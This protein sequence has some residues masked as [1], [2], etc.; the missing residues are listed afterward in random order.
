MVVSGELTNWGRY[1]KKRRGKRRSSTFGI[2]TMKANRVQ[3]KCDKA[4]S[5]PEQDFKKKEERNEKEEKRKNSQERGGYLKPGLQGKI[6]ERC[7]GRRVGKRVVE[8]GGGVERKEDRARPHHALGR[9]FDR[10]NRIFERGGGSERIADLARRKH[11]H[12]DEI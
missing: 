10:K 8:G 3:E 9:R 7:G 2:A 4:P 11:E 5:S 6:K 1:W 12:Q